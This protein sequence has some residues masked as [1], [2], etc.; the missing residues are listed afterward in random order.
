MMACITGKKEHDN[1]CATHKDIRKENCVWKGIQHN[2][3]TNTF[4]H[5]FQPLS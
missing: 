4:V 5:I 3:H 1:P 2:G